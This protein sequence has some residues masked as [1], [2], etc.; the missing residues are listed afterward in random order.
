MYKQAR[1]CCHTWAKL[2]CTVANNGENTSLDNF[3]KWKWRFQPIGSK[4]DWLQWFNNA[5]EKNGSPIL[6]IWKKKKHKR[7]GILQKPLQ[8]LGPL[9]IWF[10]GSVTIITLSRIRKTALLGSYLSTKTVQDVH[11]LCSRYLCICQPR[12]CRMFTGCAL[13]IYVS[14]NQDCAGCSL[15]VL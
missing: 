5:S 6:S 15:V 8:L 7:S 4:N 2:S 13:D 12:L 10:L 11:W 14:V 3:D 9:I 1:L